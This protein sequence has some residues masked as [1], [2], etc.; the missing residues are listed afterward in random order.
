MSLALPRFPFGQPHDEGR[1]AWHFQ[2][3][4]EFGAINRTYGD[5]PSTS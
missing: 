4:A 2:R 5:T 3:V 1:P